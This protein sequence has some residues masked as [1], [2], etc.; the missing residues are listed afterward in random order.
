MIFRVGIRCL[1]CYTRLGLFKDALKLIE[2]T[3][4]LIDPMD[5]EARA[6]YLKAKEDI[7]RKLAYSKRTFMERTDE[8]DIVMDSYKDT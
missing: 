8:L 2:K 4:T 7:D 3:L 6:L 5:V 1:K